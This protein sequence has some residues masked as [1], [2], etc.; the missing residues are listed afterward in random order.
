MGGKVVFRDMF[1]GRIIDIRPEDWL[2]LFGNEGGFGA[3]IMT[4]R[5]SVCFGIETCGSV[6]DGVFVMVNVC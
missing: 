5:E 6:L 2:A 1:G 3:P 4:A